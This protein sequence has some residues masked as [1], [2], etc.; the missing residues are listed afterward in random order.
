E[1]AELKGLVAPYRETNKPVNIDALDLSWGQFIGPI[2]SKARV[3]VKMNGPVGIS[4]PEPFRALAL[5]GISS[6]AIDLDLGAA[7][8]ESTR[9]FALEP[10]TVDVG[11]L[12]NAALKISLTNVAREVFSLNPLQA[13]I[14]A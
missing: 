6:T 14:M 1:G 12:G 9:G 4:D 3:T 8:A 5:G 10:A 2:P 7:W 11:G 13:A